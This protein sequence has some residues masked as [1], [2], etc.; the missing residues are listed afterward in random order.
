MGRVWDTPLEK[1]LGAKSA[2]ATLEKLGEINPTELAFLKL[3]NDPIWE[4]YNT[5]KEFLRIYEQEF[6]K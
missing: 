2:R 4:Q 3:S 5:A 6:W 1:V